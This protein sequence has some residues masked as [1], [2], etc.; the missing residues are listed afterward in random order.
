[1][2]IDADFKNFQKDTSLISATHANRENLIR[3]GID[4]EAED[5]VFGVQNVYCGAHCRVHGVGWC[6]VRL[7]QKRPLNATER[8]DAIAEAV[9]LGLVAA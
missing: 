5:T 9:A 1:M 6:T 4:P 2:N 7:L 8:S 3:L